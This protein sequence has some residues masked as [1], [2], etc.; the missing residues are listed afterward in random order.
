MQMPRIFV[1][2]SPQFIPILS[3]VMSPI[4]N[5]I[6]EKLIPF[7]VFGCITMY[8]VLFALRANLLAQNHSY[9]SFMASLAFVLRISKS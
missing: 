2:E 3:N 1:A 8:L 9:I 4:F 7:V 6:L 5:F